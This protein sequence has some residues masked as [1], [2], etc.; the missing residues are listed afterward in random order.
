VQICDTNELPDCVRRVQKQEMEMCAEEQ[1][2]LFVD[3]YSH[4]YIHIHAIDSSDRYIYSYIYSYTPTR[5]T[6]TYKRLSIYCNDTAHSGVQIHRLHADK[7][8]TIPNNQDHPLCSLSA[9][10]PSSTLLL[11]IKASSNYRSSL[12][13]VSI[14]FTISLHYPKWIDAITWLS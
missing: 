12:W 13:L 14:R 2:C 6:Q 5:Y 9:Y 7:N 8:S 1:I 3:I 10:S 11:A 4:V